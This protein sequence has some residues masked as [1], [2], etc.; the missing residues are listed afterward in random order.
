[1]F[2]IRVHKLRDL[3]FY[4]YFKLSSHKRIYLVTFKCAYSFGFV[5][6]YIFT[7]FAI[8]YIQKINIC[9]IILWVRIG[10]AFVEILYITLHCKRVQKLKPNCQSFMAQP[11]FL[12]KHTSTKIDTYLCSCSNTTTN[13][14]NLF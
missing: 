8:Q 2:S 10:N 14:F 12:A 1:M 11:T 9:V 3:Y 7:F 13:I 4:V 6:S 5:R